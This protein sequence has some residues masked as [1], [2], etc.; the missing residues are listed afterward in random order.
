[1][2]AITTFLSGVSDSHLAIALYTLFVPS[3]MAKFVPGMMAKDWPTLPSWSWSV[4]GLWEL[5]AVYCWYTG[6]VERCFQLLASYMG[7]VLCGCT[8][9]PAFKV[10]PSSLHSFPTASLSHLTPPPNP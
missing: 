5:A 10:R 4:M 2:E 6:D 9:V 8:A 7:G 1:M 3:S